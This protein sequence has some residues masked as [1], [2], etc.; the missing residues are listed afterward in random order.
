MGEEKNTFGET[1]HSGAGS[2]A[3]ARSRGIGWCISELDIWWTCILLCKGFSQ[4]LD[5]S[6]HVYEHWWKAPVLFG[7]VTGSINPQMRAHMFVN[8]DQRHCDREIGPIKWEVTWQML[9]GMQAREEFV[10]NLVSLASLM[11]LP[12]NLSFDG[13]DFPVGR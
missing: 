2:L 7:T 10:N 12:H 5:G 6:T 8:I 13:T 1:L 11:H 9:R 3:L 4:L